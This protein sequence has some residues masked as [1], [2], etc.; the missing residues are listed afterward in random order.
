M[1]VLASPENCESFHWR[2]VQEKK[3]RNRTYLLTF[4]VKFDVNF[5]GYT[6]PIQGFHLLIIYKY[7]CF[8]LSL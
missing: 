5:L 2:K 4:K 7:N 3:E 6:V 8:S 1:E